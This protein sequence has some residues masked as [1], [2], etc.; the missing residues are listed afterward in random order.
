MPLGFILQP[1]YRIESNRPV[2]HLYGKLQS[3]ESFLVRDDRQRPHF[4]ILADDEEKAVEL[5]A[6]LRG[7]RG[8]RSTMDRR[9]VLR[10]ELEIPQQAPPLRDRLSAA[11]IECFEADVR[12]AYRYLIDRGIR[13]TL[14]IEGEERPG[15]GV[16][17]LFEN[18]LVGPATWT[19]E[20]SVLS[21]DIETDPRARKLY[22]IG[23]SGCGAD[24]VLIHRPE[25]DSPTN[26]V[27]FRSERELLQ[28]FVRRVRELDP[29]VLTGWNVVGFDLAVLAR[30][31]SGCGVRLTLGRGPE[32]L[33][34][35][36]AGGQ[37]GGSDAVLPGRVVLDGIDLLRGAF[38][39]MESYAL[40]A[41]AL[42]LLGKGKTIHGSDRAAEITRRWREDPAALADYNLVDAQ[43][44][45]EI[46][47]RLRLIPLT[48]ERSTLT[49]MPPDRVSASVASFDYLYLSEL[50][51]RGRVAP[52]V[53]VGGDLGEQSGGHV[54][55]PKTGLHR[56]VLVFDFQSLYPSLMRTFNI[57]PLA[58][59]DAAWDD[60]PIEAPNGAKF[61]RCP[62]ILPGLLDGLAPLRRAARKAGD[63]VKSQAVKI[64]MNSFYGVLGT[65]ACRFAAPGL[66][67]AITG[68]GRE[69]LL[70]TKARFEE[71]GY[72][73]LYGDTDSLFVASGAAD[74]EDAAACARELEREINETLREIVQHRWRVENR[75]VL[76]FE[77]LYL[78]LLLPAG[79][80]GGG[81]AR[82]RYA[83]LVR[84]A[85]GEEVVLTGLEAVRRDWTGLAR[86]AQRELFERLFRDRDVTAYLKE[87]V[88][89]LRRGEFDDELVYR[90][91]LRRSLDSYTA[92]TPPHVAAARKLRGPP[93]RV[94]RY[95]ITSSG[96]EPAAERSAA[97]DYE[98]YVQKQVRGVAEPVLGILGLDFDQVIG[99]DTQLRLF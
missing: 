52:M 59:I 64:L 10:V 91:T 15:N 81:G 5:G 69:I 49:G 60:D 93:P 72:E 78:R 61:A 99:D 1:T 97:I 19:P 7:E 82:K 92:T 11:G 84:T 37:R 86:R 9:P 17:V 77:K 53:G 96:P 98:H 85:E 39:K 21:L 4:W 54:L 57:D 62:A 73:V 40:N 20:L 50:S 14:T 35:R 2:V 90:K 46:L 45:L 29:D 38:V 44:V 65:S 41:V 48:V 67:N 95:Y 31:A 70:W 83:G 3:G 8:E 55:D 66:A 6:R 88:V 12:F 79:K 89:G 43:L 36:S 18:P 42:A 30:I 32:P 25:G 23:L 74:P 33:R 28:A 27:G 34:V 22:S 63:E 26:A 13:G 47:E 94:V 68:F 76:E 56:N 71:L 80:Q 24:E 75:L 58:M 87:L 16:D 51:K